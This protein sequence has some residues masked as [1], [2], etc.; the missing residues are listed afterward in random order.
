MPG[1]FERLQQKIEIKQKAG[2]ITPMDL[3]ELSPAMRRIVRLLLRELQMDYPQ[4]LEAVRAM[5]AEDRI[6][7]ENLRQAL[8]TL[9]QQFWL[10]RIGTDDRAIYKVNL[11]RRSGT[12]LPSG[13]WG[14][15]DAKLKQRP[16]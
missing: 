15:L 9:T 8:D 5:P 4:I 13:I 7:P 12:A 10:T 6:S 14:A 3:A 1:V 2:G 11:R 16:K